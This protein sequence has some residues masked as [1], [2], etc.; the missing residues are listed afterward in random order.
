MD[1][2]IYNSYTQKDVRKSNNEFDIQILRPL[3][4]SEFGIEISWPFFYDGFDIIIPQP[5]EDGGFDIIIPPQPT[6]DYGIDI[7][8][9]PQPIEDDVI[10]IIRLPQP[11]EDDRI[12]RQIPQPTED[13][14]INILIYQ[15]LIEEVIKP[16]KKTEVMRKPGLVKN[17][18]SEGLYIRTTKIF[19][20]GK[21][22]R[23]RQN[24]RTGVYLLLYFSIIALF[25]LN[26]IFYKF[27]F[28]FT[29]YIYIY[30]SCAIIFS[31]VKIIKLR[32]CSPQLLSK[33]FFK[34]YCW[35]LYL[36]KRWF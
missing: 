21:Y 25:G 3:E 16:I 8:R 5:I 15:P 24:Y 12:N 18:D 23:T 31:F 33:Q 19:N 22:S 30:Y 27:S 26:Y 9:L 28:N 1:Y 20:K 35:F 6:E 17:V 2:D 13:D 4:N 14:R 7:I 29:G 11:T 36:I 32:I 34:I 10:D